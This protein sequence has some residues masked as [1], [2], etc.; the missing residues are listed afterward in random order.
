MVIKYI[1][2]FSEW[3]ATSDLS[4]V[5]FCDFTRFNHKWFAIRDDPKGS[6]L[7]NCSMCT[8]QSVRHEVL[9]FRRSRHSTLLPVAW[10][11]WRPKFRAVKSQLVETNVYVDTILTGVDLQIFNHDIGKSMSSS[12]PSSK[13]F[14]FK[15]EIL[16]PSSILTTG[17]CSENVRLFAYWHDLEGILPL[18]SKIKQYAANERWHFM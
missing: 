18:C 7:R 16:Q 6:Y 13:F 11:P 9:S 14:C 2:F 3:Q 5:F 4:L 15:P 17:G 1:I 12:L 10:R 8:F